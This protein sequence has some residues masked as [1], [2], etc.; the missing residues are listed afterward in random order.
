M[1][2]RRS[3]VLCLLAMLPALAMA[4]PLPARAGDGGRQR[5][6]DKSK[7]IADALDDPHSPLTIQVVGTCLS[8]SPSGA[9]T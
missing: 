8:T 4:L 2:R 6:C 7:T 3:L 5:R 9:A 1:T